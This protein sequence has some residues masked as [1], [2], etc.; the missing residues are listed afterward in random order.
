MQ[1]ISRRQA[2]LLGGL[3]VAGTAAGGAGLL[4]TLTSQPEPVP[5]GE[6]SQPPEERSVDGVLR[7]RLEAAPGQMLLGGRKAAAL[8][9]NQGIPGPTLRLRAG[10][11]LQIRLVNNLSE[12]TNLHVH[13]LH[14]SPQGNGDNIFVSVGPGSSFDYEYKLPPEHPPGVY[15]YHPHHHGVVADQIFAG[16]FGAIIVE[17]PEPVEVSLDRVLL[18][19]DTTLDGLGNIAAAPAMERM[20]GR[21]GEL[22]LVNGQSNPQLSARPGERER[23][24]IVNACVAR[25]LRLRLD[26]QQLQLLGMDSGRFQEPEKVDELLLT[27]GNRADLLVT[28][29][30]GDAVLRAFYQNR[31]SMPGMM[32]PGFRARNPAGQ[33]DGAVLAT[34]R[35]TG[36]R[37]TPPT[38][39][40]AQQG[41]GDLRSSPVAARRQIILAAGM[42]MGPGAGMMRFTINGREFDEARTDTTA[43][44]GDI[45]EWILTNTSPMDHPF[46]LHV[47]PMQIIEQNNQ[48][49]G[50]PVW[51]DVVN[52]PANGRTKVRVAFKDFR[53]R[54]VYHCHI[55]DHEDL[56][57][58]GV[59]EVR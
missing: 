59:I 8:G 12:A 33:S 24:R 29:T 25:Y 45:E 4:W 51:Q 55:L 27:P 36:D 17:D 38:A 43:A 44:A 2:L 10:D 39:V 9:Y 54:S 16:L 35:V 7:I 3:G 58:M 20:M 19:S 50:A 57:M 30:A 48:Q 56:G 13:G 31:G 22:L 32:G 28:T 11:V 40:P 46:H 6:L 18:V 53:G 23:W 26:G 5:G 14:T 47:W 1:P 42:G 21:E 41:L 49:P 52:V 34:L 37:V 15:W